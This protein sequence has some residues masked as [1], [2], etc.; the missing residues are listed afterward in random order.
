MIKIHTYKELILKGRLVE[1]FQ[2]KRYGLANVLL[3]DFRFCTLGVPLEQHQCEFSGLSKIAY[4]ARTDDRITP[5]KFA[6]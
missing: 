2:F 4:A 1:S 5:Q 3:N 6:S